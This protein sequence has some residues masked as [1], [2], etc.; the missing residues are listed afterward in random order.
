MDLIK[1]LLKLDINALIV[2]CVSL[3]L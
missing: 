3:V 2:E 1:R